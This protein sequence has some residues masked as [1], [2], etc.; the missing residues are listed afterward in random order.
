[1]PSSGGADPSPGVCPSESPLALPSPQPPLEEE[2]GLF[3]GYNYQEGELPKP[4]LAAVCGPH[5]AGRG[6][7]P[8]WAATGRPGAG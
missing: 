3:P 1:M 4:G 2:A 5:A 7:C 6:T 8:G